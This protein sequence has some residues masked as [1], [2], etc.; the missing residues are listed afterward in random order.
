VA[1]VGS[2][3]VADALLAL[4]AM[5]AN[6]ASLRNR[7][8]IP[9]AVLDDAANR[10]PAEAAVRLFDLA[11]DDLHDPIVGLRAGL[12]LRPRGP[13]VFLLLAGP[14]TRHA[15]RSYTRLARLAL[16]SVEVRLVE[17]TNHAELTWD[18]GDPALRASHHL[19]DFAVTSGLSAMRVAIP[20]MAPLGIDLAHPEIGVPGESARAL[21]CT[22]RFDRRVAAVRISMA[23]LA[24]R[25]LAA[26]PL[27]AEQLEKM[28]QA[29]LANVTA[30]SAR[31]RVAATVRRMLASGAAPHRSDVAKHLHVSERTLQRQLEQE[32][33]TFKQVRDGV[34][35]ELSQAL[36]SDGSMKVEAIAHSVGFSEVASFS[37]AFARWS[38]G[39][40]TNYRASIAAR[41]RRRA[42]ARAPR[43]R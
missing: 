27:V 26:N 16:D 7:A 28:H 6:A 18:L 39:S 1:T 3:Q 29:L 35:T 42:S 19:F 34:R 31:D 12:H 13:L 5:G 38:G 24:A 30:S 14:D 32:G 20:G 10:L 8:G 36:L 25:T 11:A 33:A 41:G 15:L 21:G 9:G 22:V 2:I 37:K 43:R 23:T 40:P 17:R 4:E